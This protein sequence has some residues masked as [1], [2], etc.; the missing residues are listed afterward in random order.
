MK[1]VLTGLLCLGAFAAAQDVHFDYDRATNFSAFKT[2]QWV[3]SKAGG[4]PSQLMD[5]NIK[6]AVDQQL[7]VK[8]TAACRQW[9]RLAGRLPRGS[10]PGE[11]V[12][13]L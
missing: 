12:R 3:D 4:A 7:A 8:G 5:Q 1:L 10:Q 9:R 13:R 2:Y 11:A 6:R